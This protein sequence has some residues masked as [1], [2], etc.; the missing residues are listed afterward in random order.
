[1]YLLCL[2]L[3]FTVTLL[4]LGHL[5]CLI[6]LFCTLLCPPARLSAC[7][8]IIDLI[9]NILFNFLL[10]LKNGG[11][12]RAGITL[13]LF[14]SLAPSTYLAV[15]LTVEQLLLS[16]SVDDWSIFGSPWFFL[17]QLPAGVTCHSCIP[18]AK[19]FKKA[20]RFLEWNSNVLEFQIRDII[21][22]LMWWL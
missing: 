5:R 20:K 10:S 19:F 22:S 9:G 16:K 14:P 4:Y 17:F 21:C 13:V 2:S 8:C 12:M 1:M 11:S 6:F 3:G 15:R 7:T 18:R